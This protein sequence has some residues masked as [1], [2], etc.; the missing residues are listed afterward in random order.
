V[1]GPVPCF[2]SRMGGIYRWQIILSGTD[3]ATFLR[4]RTLNDWKIEVNPP[5][6][7]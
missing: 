6:L 2:F 4:G 5:N 1:I 3:L 7:L